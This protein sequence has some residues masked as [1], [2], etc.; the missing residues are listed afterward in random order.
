MEIH[1]EPRLS[2]ATLARVQYAVHQALRGRAGPDLR[3]YVSRPRP[4]L[5]SVFISGLPEHPLAVTE[6]IETTLAGGDR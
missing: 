2:R 3:V 5:W 4:G 1:V 6:L